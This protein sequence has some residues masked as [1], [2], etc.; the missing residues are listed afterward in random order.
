MLRTADENMANAIRLIAVERGLDTARL[1]ADRLRR[2]R[3]AARA[4]RRRAA[5]HERPSSSRRIPGSARRSA[6]RSPRRGS[7]ACRRYFTTFG[8]L[9]L[10]GLAARSSGCAKPRSPSCA[11]ASHVGETGSRSFGRHALCRPELR[12]RGPLP[13]GEFDA[14]GWARRCGVSATRTRS[15]MASRC[16]ASRSRSSICGS[17]A[18]SPEPRPRFR[19]RE[20]RGDVRSRRA[21]PVWFDAAR[22]PI[23]RI[24]SS[25][26]ALAASGRPRRAGGDR[27]DGFDHARL[28]GRR[29]SRSRR[30]A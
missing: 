11:P 26:A 13:A 4:R 14:A 30:A 24:L 25:R 6:P 15:S 8:D 28:S 5:R 19:R 3:A 22:Q 7:T 21:A 17:T 23:A 20:R 9:D 12:G 27:G 16:R 2:R 29:A 18:I 1:R 10:A